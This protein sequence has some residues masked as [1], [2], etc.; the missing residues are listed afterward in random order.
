M[1][2]NK[3][4]NFVIAALLTLGTWLNANAVTVMG[5]RSC[6]DWVKNAQEQNGWPRIAQTAWLGGFLSGK[7]LGTGVD[8]L[9]GQSGESLFLWVDNYCRSNPLNDSADAGE[10]LFIELKKKSR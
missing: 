1:K 2:K 6:G 7:A 3:F 9:K 10:E 8:V 5:T 4:Q